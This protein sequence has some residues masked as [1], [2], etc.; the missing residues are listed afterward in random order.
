MYNTDPMQLKTNINQYKFS[1]IKEILKHHDKL[2]YEKNKVI[3]P[4]YISNNET[5]N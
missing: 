3:R 4:I 5:L 2:N 1:F